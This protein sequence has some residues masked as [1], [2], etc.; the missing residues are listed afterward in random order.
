VQ[1]VYE[2]GT[3][4]SQ[5]RKTRRDTKEILFIISTFVYFVPFVVR[6]KSLPTT[7]KNVK[8]TFVPFVVNDSFVINH[9]QK[10]N[11]GLNKKLAQDASFLC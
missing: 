6:R 1:V 9:P 7:K 10:S 4:D 2:S 8:E 5:T 11:L 3:K